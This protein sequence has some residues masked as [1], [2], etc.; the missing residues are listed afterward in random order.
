MALAKKLL[1]RNNPQ[2][3]SLTG[4]IGSGKSVVAKIFKVLDV[5]VFDADR[6][7]KKILA[8]DDQVRTAVKSEFGSEAY[9]GSLPNRKFLA[10]AVFKNE[11]KRKKLNALIHPKVGEK[12]REFCMENSDKSYVVKEA[13]IAIETGSH[14]EMDAVVLVTAPEELRIKRVT[15]RDGSDENE[16]RNRIKAQWTDEEK[17]PYATFEIVN[18]DHTAVIPSVLQ[19]HN[20]ILRFAS[21]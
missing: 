5:P 1:Q 17:R 20:T 15:E 21:V 8:E 9:E 2:K 10:Q 13:A 7:A 3:I 16:V 11:E 18:D 4:G 14:E 6:E 12:F 19:I